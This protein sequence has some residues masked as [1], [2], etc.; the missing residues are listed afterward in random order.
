MRQQPKSKRLH[1][2]KEKLEYSHNGFGDQKQTKKNYI[3]KEIIYEKS[4]K[5]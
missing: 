2:K 5:Q 4:R 1:R 3:Y